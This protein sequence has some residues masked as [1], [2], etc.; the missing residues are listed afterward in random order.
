MRPQD[1]RDLGSTIAGGGA[2]LLLLNSVDWAAIAH[3]QLVKLSVAI[4]L[5]LLGYVMYKA[6]KDRGT[7][8]PP[9]AP[10]GT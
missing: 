5:I 1:V 6:N 9:S 2:G 10:S 7:P 4:L 3:G 8:D